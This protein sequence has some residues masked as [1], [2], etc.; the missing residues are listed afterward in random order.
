MVPRLSANA[1]RRLA[2][3]KEAKRKWDRVHAL[4]EQAATNAGTREVFLRQCQRA[5][6]DVQRL[7][8]GDGFKELADATDQ[9]KTVIKR[10]GSF[11]ARLG[12]MREVVGLI[13]TGID[14]A[15]KA[16]RDSDKQAGVD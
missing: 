16:V 6:Q 15:D 3:L 2:V 5:A 14:R 7:L 9:L 8:E 10:P 1:L 11:Q 13:H 4:V 12:S